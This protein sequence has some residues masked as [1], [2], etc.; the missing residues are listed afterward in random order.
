MELLLLVLVLANRRHR[1]QVI[2]NVLRLTRAPTLV[3]SAYRYFGLTNL[4]VIA[5]VV[6]MMLLL[7]AEVILWLLLHGWLLAGRIGRCYNCRGI[8]TV[9]RP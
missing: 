6:M 1:L 7:L 3:H 5:V 9:K 4:T 8:I 2:D